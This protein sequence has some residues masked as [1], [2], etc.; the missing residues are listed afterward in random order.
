MPS[1]D[2]RL[3]F[4]RGTDLSD[5]SFGQLRSGVS[6]APLVVVPPLPL[7]IGYVVGIA[8]KPQVVRVDAGRYIAPVEHMF[9]WRNRTIGKL[10]SNTMRVLVMVPGADHSVAFSLAPKPNVAA[11][12]WTGLVLSIKSFAKRHVHTV[13]HLG[14][15]GAGQL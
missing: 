6:A 5:V 2:S 7:A 1:S 3:A 4:C 14:V 10:I 13:A 9:S 11:R 15:W 12:L 8:A